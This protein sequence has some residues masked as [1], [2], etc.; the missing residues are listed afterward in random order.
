M[1]CEESLNLERYMS[2]HVQEEFWPRFHKRLSGSRGI[3]GGRGNWAG[4][5][6]RRLLTLSTLASWFAMCMLL[7]KNSGMNDT[8]FSDRNMAGPEGFI[9][10][11]VSNR[12]ILAASLAERKV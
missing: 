3:D 11:L 7:T 2:G 9:T 10:L 12:P 4:K 6:L 8:N 5:A 1:A